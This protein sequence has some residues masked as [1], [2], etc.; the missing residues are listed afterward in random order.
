ML[1]D[2]VAYGEQI[3]DLDYYVNALAR[4]N[5]QRQI[6]YLGVRLQDM[7]DTCEPLAALAY[8][9]NE[10]K[11][12]QRAAETTDTPALITLADMLNEKDD[13]EIEWH[14]DGV[15]PKSD[16]LLIVAE[17]G[18]GKSVLLRQLAMSYAMGVHPFDIRRGQKPGRAML[19]DCEVSRRQLVRSLRDMYSYVAPLASGSPANLVVESRQGGIDL[20]DPVDQG[21]LLRLVREHR[22]M[23]LCMGPLYRMATGDINEE[24]NLR[25]WQRVLEPLLEW[26][27]S[28]VMEHHVGNANVGGKRDLRPIGSSVIRRWMSQGIALR[29]QECDAHGDEFCRVCGRMA[30]V[31]HWRG[32][33]DETDWPCFVRSP[34]QVAWWARG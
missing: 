16:R 33:R 30:S 28:I 32:S 27:T 19:I 8:V 21:W 25:C 22:P 13:G 29:L 10:L 31:E 12:L 34:G 1:T 7:A 18:V 24:Q 9:D 5:A 20:C 15:L 3:F 2:M 14:L 6:R 11:R 17:E 26:G 23:V 4:I